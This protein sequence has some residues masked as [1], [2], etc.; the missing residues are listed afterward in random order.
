MG[1]W[2]LRVALVAVLLPVSM[3]VLASARAQEGSAKQDLKDAGKDTKHAARKT[4]EAV[5]HAARKSGR[6]VKRTT[7]KGVHKSA[8]EIH[9]GSGKVERKTAPQQ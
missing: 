9:K 4:G 7:K 3:P 1:R 5:D 8:Q 6:V 2:I